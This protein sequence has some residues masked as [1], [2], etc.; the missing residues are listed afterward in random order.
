MLRMRASRAAE[1]ARSTS[2]R[3]LSTAAGVL[4]RLGLGSGDT[5]PVSGVY[6]GASASTTQWSGSGPV[7][8]SKNPA[9]GKVL[10][11]VQ[12]ASQDEVDVVLES[13]RDAYKYW[14]KVPAPT[15]GVVLSDIQAE[16]KRFKDDLGLLVSLEMGKIA[17]EG[18]GEVQEIIDVVEVAQGLARSIGGTVVPSERSEHFITEVANPLGVVGVIS[19]FNFPTAVYGWNFALSFTCGNSTVWKPAPTTSLSAIATTKIIASVL[20]QHKLPGSLAALVCGEGNV[21]SALVKDKRVD[22]LSFTGSEERGRQVGSA[23]A[24]RFGKTILELGGNNAAI[25]LNDANMQLALR[26][27]LFSA[28][29]TAGQRCTTTRRLFLQQ[30]IADDFL[31]SLV[32]AY[33]STSDRIG[34]PTVEGTLIGPLHSADS[35][36][37]FERAMNEIEKLGGQVLVGGKRAKVDQALAGGNWVEPTIVKVPNGGRDFPIMQ[38]E[39]FAPILYVSTFSTLEEAIELNN[40]VNQGLS[41]ALFTQNMS[42]AFKW[43]GPEGSDCG[44]VNVNGSTSGAEIGAPFGGNKSTGWGRESGGD[45]WKQSLL[46]AAYDLGTLN[47]MQASDRRKFRA[48][49]GFAK[50]AAMFTRETL[51]VGAQPA[52]LEPDQIVEIKDRGKY[53]VD[54]CIPHTPSLGAA[55]AHGQLHRNSKQTEHVPDGTVIRRW[56]YVTLVNDKCRR[57]STLKPLRHMSD[58]LADD[59]VDFLNLKPGQDALE[60]IERHLR[61]SSGESGTA[62]EDT[63]QRFWK[64]MMNEPPPELGFENPLYK[65]YQARGTPDEAMRRND[66]WGQTSQLG[67]S[68]E[69]GQAVFWRYAGSIFT[70]LMH[71]SLA[72]GFGAPHLASVMKA[73]AYL[74]SNSRDATYRRLLETTLFVLDA[75]TDMRVGKGKGWRS[76]VRVRLLHAQVRRKIR[77]GLG[78]DGKY[79]YEEHGVPINQAYYLGIDADILQEFYGTTFQDA[80]SAFASLAFDAFP[81][82]SPSDPMQT[83]TYKILSAVSERPPRKQSIGHHLQ[84]SRR[85]LGTG[86]A[87][88]LSIPRASFRDRMSVEF[89]VWCSWVFVRFGRAWFRKGWDR[90]RQSF[91]K[92][93]IPLL[94]MYNLGERRTVFAWREESRRQ[95]KLAHDEGE[96]A[97]VAMGPAVGKQVRR[98]WFWLLGEIVGG[99]VLSAAGIGAT[100]WIIASR[101]SRAFL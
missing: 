83:P 48:L 44:I 11:R 21:G 26:A 71:F 87:D 46:A 50:V 15:R 93:V 101:L 77:L 65:D 96:D 24:Q 53:R 61:R 100:T 37:R 90:D 5:T 82:H 18:R 66:R 1:V 31:S 97:D 69:E 27:T 6:H 20:E 91:V 85:L 25:V 89:D 98:E 2:Q 88:Q 47:D 62:T 3:R 67:P 63:V 4:D 9:T 10:A 86:L 32:K 19:A 39:T 7:I 36:Q 42:N 16:L 55:A 38:E 45:A 13:C 29:G 68:L 35:V 59:V 78:K 41:S 52:R 81:E 99:I 51:F 12:T 56:D 64:Q 58:S 14:R 79:D 57:P 74:T 17:S 49:V 43:I 92:R 76:T 22:L 75:M 80:E 28:L 8:E 34:D 84:Y 94:V 33:K 54:A 30:D 73:T 40:S 72:G 60:A 70:A 95:D 23:V